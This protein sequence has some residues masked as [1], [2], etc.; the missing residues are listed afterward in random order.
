MTLV[1]LVQL[2]MEHESNEGNILETILTGS[3]NGIWRFWKMAI[4]Y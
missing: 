1:P 2:L 4:E 3:S